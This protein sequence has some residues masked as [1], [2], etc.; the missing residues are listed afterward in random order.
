MHTLSAAILDNIFIHN[1]AA[2][3]ELHIFEKNQKQAMENHQD[4]EDSG[5]E[6]STNPLLPSSELDPVSKSDTSQ[7]QS[8]LKSCLAS[9]FRFP[10]NKR[11]RGH[12]RA[13]SGGWSRQCPGEPDSQ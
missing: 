7:G 11:K 6:E 2:E 9:E 10:K 5:E 8:T 1:Q 13:G 3:L 12:R 4:L